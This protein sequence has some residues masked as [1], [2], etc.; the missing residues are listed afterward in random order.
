[1]AA[2]SGR[3]PR[4]WARARV[5]ALLHEMDLDGEREDYIAEIIRLSQKYKF[6]TPY[7]AFLAAPRA[8][9]R[10][11]LIQPGDPVIRVKTDEAITSVF[12]VLPFG[13]TLPLKF[14]PAEGVWEGR[15]LAPAWM[16]DGT[17]HCR[18][19][20]SDRQGNGYQEEKSFVIDSHAPKLKISVA[21]PTVRAGD[22]VLVRVAADSDTARLVA[23]MYGA[24]PAQLFWSDKEKTNVGRLRVPRGLAAGRYMLTV[25]AE[26][27]AHNQSSAEAQIEVLAHF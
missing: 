19:L 7:T 18:L 12:A 9:L 15:F 5:D 26:D 16:P 25:S 20:M 10:P 23:R 8:L 4:L 1:M 27:F 13:E 17:Y 2:R 11:R 21:S 6:V 3:P 22:E 14:L 24:Q